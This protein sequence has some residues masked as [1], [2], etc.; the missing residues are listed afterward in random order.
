MMYCT[1][2]WL[3]LMMFLAP[4]AATAATLTLEGIL[5]QG[6]LVLGCT[7][8]GAQVVFDNR[9]VQVS[10]KGVFLIGF[11]RDAGRHASLLITYPDGSE[12]KRPLAVAKRNYRIQSIHGLP[13]RKVEPTPSDQ[14]RIRTEAQL[15]LQARRRDDPRSD[16]LSGFM[17]PVRG[18]ISGVYGSQ[19]I[20]NGVA[21]R[22]HYGID[23]AASEGT[24]VVA[25]ADGLVTLVYEDMFFSG[26]TLI[27]DHGHGLSSSFLHLSRILVRPGQTVNQGETIAEVGASGRVTDAHL[28]WRVNLFEKRLDPALVVKAIPARREATPPGSQ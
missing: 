24:P 18:R 23:I 12:V 19:R 10:D 8:P 5:T 27:L 16:F 4:S 28:D 14:Q 15:V 3:G 26:G 20:L 22:P 21:R 9:P 6:A 11:G 7:Q 25:P 1:G 17:W 2:A 13:P